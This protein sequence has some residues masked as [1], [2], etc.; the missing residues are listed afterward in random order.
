[1]RRTS[2]RK[3]RMTNRRRRPA[4]RRVCAMFAS[5]PKQGRAQ[6]SIYFMGARDLRHS[7]RFSRRVHHESAAAAVDQFSSEKRI[8]NIHWYQA[9]STR[10]HGVM[11]L[12]GSSIVIVVIGIAAYAAAGPVQVKHTLYLRVIV[13]VIS[14]VISFYFHKNSS[15]YYK[16]IL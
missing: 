14:L 9:S 6:P 3:R 7:T 16:I 8:L 11:A 15:F 5:L 13:I 10:R 2:H 1:M 12:S 4:A